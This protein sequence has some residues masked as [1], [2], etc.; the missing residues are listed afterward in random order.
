M[1]KYAVVTGASS[2]IGLELA[3]ILAKD[4]YDLMLVARDEDALS[5]LATELEKT[6]NITVKYAS[7]DLSVHGAADSLWQKLDTERPLDILINNAGF[8]DYA[9]VVEANPKRLSSMIT[10]NIETLTLL[11]TYTARY[12]KNRG[13]GKIMNVASLAGFFPGANMA[14]YYATKAYVLSFSE[15]LAQELSHSPVTVT[16]LCPGPT[17]THF[18]EAAHATNVS[19]FQRQMP[20]ARDVAQYGYRAMLRGKVV[21]VPGVGNKLQA[22]VL[23]RFIPRFIIRKTVDY[24][25]NR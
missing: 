18:Q 13:S 19:F 17:A 3:K 6:H 1:N 10:L 12:M 21:A 8:G 23:P 20:T 11:S 7:L 15:A 24:A 4:T 16:A 9:P 2:G 25:Q 5:T 14:T 22:F